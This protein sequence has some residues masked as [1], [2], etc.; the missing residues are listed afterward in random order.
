[1]ISHRE[2]T[3]YQPRLFGSECLYIFSLEIPRGREQSMGALEAF[4]TPCALP[5]RG[6]VVGIIRRPNRL[7]V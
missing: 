5:W 3:P 1:M 6:R 2:T 4:P 7:I